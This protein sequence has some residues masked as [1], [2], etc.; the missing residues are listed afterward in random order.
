MTMTVPDAIERG[1]AL[2]VPA[3]RAVVDRLHPRLRHVVA[4]HRGWVDA[5]NKPLTGSGGKLVRPALALLSAE[6][7]GA[8]P[9]V[10]L[11]AACAVELVHDFS[12]LHDDLM[13]GDTERRHRATA[14]TVFGADGAI[15]AGDALL[16]LAVQILLEVEGDPARRAALILSAGVQDL[17]RGQAEDLMFERRTDVT[18]AD[19]LNMEDGKTG[20][21]LACS[22]SLGAVLAG[23]DDTMIAGLSEYGSRLGTAFQ[24]IDDLLGIWGDPA[25]TGKPVLSDL[26]S[27][28]KSVP[29]VV[30][31]EAGG[32]A[33]DE[34]RAFLTATGTSSEAEL[35]HIAAL[36]ERAGGREWTTAEADRQLKACESVLR[37]LSMPAQV[38]A[39]LVALARFVTER[40]R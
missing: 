13:D 5:E 27:R 10:G 19:T 32:P 6:A 3:L 25:V 14:W 33:A 12:L 18:V 37:S 23:A 40:D 9:E 30:A 11:P 28:K 7:A 2:T 29:V 16:G 4:Y 26:R 31:L 17:V 35:A 22:A 21:L 15:L 8:P 36:V 38:E 20:A 1:R 24:L 39:E 34:L